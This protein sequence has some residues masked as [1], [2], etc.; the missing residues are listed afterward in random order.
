MA[1]KSWIFKDTLQDLLKGLPISAKISISEDDPHSLFVT[2]E[3]DKVMGRLCFIEERYIPWAGGVPDGG[4]RPSE[5]V[6]KMPRVFE[7]DNEPS[8]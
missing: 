5:T 4:M 6:L 3:D 2:G 8:N 7:S 1:A